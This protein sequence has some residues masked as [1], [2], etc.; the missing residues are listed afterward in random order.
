MRKESVDDSSIDRADMKGLRTD[1]ENVVVLND[2]SHT[3][4]PMVMEVEKLPCVGEIL[5]KRLGK[6]GQKSIYGRFIG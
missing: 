6:C 5:A 1:K 2:A 4:F 3:F